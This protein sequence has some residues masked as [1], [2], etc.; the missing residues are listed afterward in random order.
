MY[1][2]VVYLFLVLE[3][4]LQH[5]TRT[6]K[7]Q[8]RIPEQTQTIPSYRQRTAL[9]RCTTCCSDSGAAVDFFSSTATRNGSG[10]RSFSSTRDKLQFNLVVFFTNS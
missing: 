5:Q 9:T 6:E 3:N 7:G 1:R 10:S 2:T 8:D 4:K